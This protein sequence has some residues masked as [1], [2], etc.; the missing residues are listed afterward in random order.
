MRSSYLWAAFIALT[1]GGWFGYNNME[2]LGLKQATA[3]K[4]VVVVEKKPAEKAFKVE[5]RTFTAKMRKKSLYARGRTQVKKQVSVLARTNGIVEQANFEEGDAVKSGDLLCRLDMRD[6]KARLAQARAQLVSNKRDYEA[7]LKLVA[8]KFASQAKLASERARYDAALASVEQIELD[9][10]Y[11]NIT[12]P[13]S[14]IITSF[15]GE[16]G[17]FLQAGKPCAIISVFDPI[18]VIA[19]VGERE[20]DLVKVGQQASARLVT[21]KIL[22]GIVTKI[23][24]TADI[25]TRTFKIKI[26][27]ENPGNRL[28]DGIT[29][30]VVLPLA[31]VKAHLIP[32]GIVGLNDNGEIGV[33]TIVNGNKVAFR[34]VKLVGQTREGTW[35]QGLPDEVRIITAGQDYVLDG[36]TVEP[37]FAEEPQS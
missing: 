32:A 6:R 26:S 27:V 37:V 36:Q 35:V 18:V 1:I 23:S 31:P 16:K 8:R 15:Q 19:Q 10:S 30:E 25:A 5:V 12:A 4:P 28:R 17:S 22:K 21:G 2:K 11:T 7:S 24:P 3:E 34:V 20:I 33:R 9:I 13:I 14:G 29:A